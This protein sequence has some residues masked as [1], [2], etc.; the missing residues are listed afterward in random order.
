MMAKGP[1]RFTICRTAVSDA[2]T[3]AGCP[4]NVLQNEGRGM[5]HASEGPAART[6]RGRN[7]LPK[8]FD[9]QSTCAVAKSARQ[10]K[11]G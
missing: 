6:D 5:S 8:Q 11:R 3:G 10:N 4:Q 9:C 1:Y 7:W 2:A